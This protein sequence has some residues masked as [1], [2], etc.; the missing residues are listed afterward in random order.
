MMKRIGIL[1]GSFDPVHIGHT[2][3]GNF[4]AQSGLVDEVWLM[5]SPQNPFKMDC[6]LTGDTHRMEMLRIATEGRGNILRPCDI[7]LTMPRP[8]YTIHTL[9]AL[10]GT[11]P[12]CSF[13]LIIGGDNWVKFDR[14]REHNAILREFGVIIYPREGCDFDSD[15]IPANV[16]VVDA[17]K[18]EVSSTWIR[19]AIA[20]GR[21]VNYF[22]PAGVYQYIKEHNLYHNG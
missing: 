9:R 3:L 22:M 7:E 1:G 21:D 12:D 20:E 18:V 17:P 8:S 2:A 15:N 6:R 19:R 11:Y 5:L 16:T 14:W 13:R 4:I 10:R